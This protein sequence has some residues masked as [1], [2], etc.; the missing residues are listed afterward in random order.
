MS[1]YLCICLWFSLSLTLYF[2][3]SFSLIL[4]FSSFP[5]F[6][7]P[8]IQSLFSLFCSIWLSSFSFLIVFHSSSIHLLHLL[9]L[10]L[11]SFSYSPRFPPILS[12]FPSPPLPANV[13][14]SPPSSPPSSPFF[15]FS[16]CFLSFSAS[17]LFSSSFPSSP[18]LS[19]LSPPSSISLPPSPPPS[20]C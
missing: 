9:I 8:F 15:L 19:G 2:C 10:F 13:L 12:S 6:L 1:L 18:P 4:Y 14:P 17:Y 5:S 11:S 16:F 20:S 3:L 7:C